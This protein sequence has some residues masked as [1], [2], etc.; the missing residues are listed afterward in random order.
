MFKRI[1]LK[2]EKEELSEPTQGLQ[3]KASRFHKVPTL[4]KKK[5]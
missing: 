3:T 2:T 5:K 4:K 1:G